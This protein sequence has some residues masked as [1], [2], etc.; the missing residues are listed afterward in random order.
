VGSLPFVFSGTLGPVDAYFESMS[1]LTTTGSTVISDIE[2]CAKS[3]LFWRSFTHWIGGMGIIVLFIAVLPYLGVGGKHLF[4]SESSANPQSISPRIKDTA[5]AL[6]KIYLGLTIA[7][8]I[9]LMFAGMS[10]YD[11]LC[12]TFG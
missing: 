8:T 4:K 11:S 10:F 5:S 1:G 2:S 6:W 9:A 3:I 7:Q 12:H